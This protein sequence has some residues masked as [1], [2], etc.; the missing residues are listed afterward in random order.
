MLAKNIFQLEKNDVVFIKTIS[1]GLNIPFVISDINYFTELFNVYG[2]SQPIKF[3][4]DAIDKLV[5][6]EISE[7]EIKLSNLNLNEN[8]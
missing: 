4:I 6:N 1:G 7:L 5:Y 2:I 8:I 3:N